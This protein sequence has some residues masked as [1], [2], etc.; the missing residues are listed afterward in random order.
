MRL[1][2]EAGAKQL[3]I[4]HHEPNHEDDFKDALSKEAK[5]A[6]DGNLVVRE[7]MTIEL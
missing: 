7:G 5:D 2:Q 6:W 1:C 3:G 4:F